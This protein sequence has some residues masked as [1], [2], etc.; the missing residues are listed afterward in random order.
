MMYQR[1]NN[2]MEGNIFYQRGKRGR[3]LRGGDKHIHHTRN[4]CSGFF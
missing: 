2:M 3:K 1:R 4:K